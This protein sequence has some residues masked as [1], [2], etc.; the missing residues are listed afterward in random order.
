[1]TINVMELVGS[2][3]YL[4]PPGAIV[5]I[6]IKRWGQITQKGMSAILDPSYDNCHVS[7]MAI[8]DHHIPSGKP[9]SFTLVRG[10]SFPATFLADDTKTKGHEFAP[11]RQFYD[12][13]A[14]I[15]Q[16]ERAASYT[17]LKYKLEHFAPA[18][19]LLDLEGEV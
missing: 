3:T 1:M 16:K 2:M 19:M 5:F 17:A 10:E 6:N 11:G 8:R 12:E 4:K 7:N 13:F 9:V 14:S 15:S 18:A